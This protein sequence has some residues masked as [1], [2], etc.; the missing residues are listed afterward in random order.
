MS[1][2]NCSYNLWIVNKTNYQSE[3]CLQKPKH[4]TILC[5]WAG[6]RYNENLA[7]FVVP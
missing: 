3:P 7:G 4:V 1:R 2:F 5:G 6:M